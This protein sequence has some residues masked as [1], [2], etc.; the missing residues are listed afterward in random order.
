MH[1]CACLWVELESRPIGWILM[2]R[3]PRTCMIEAGEEEAVEEINQE[4]SDKVLE[5]DQKYNEIHRPVYDNRSQIIKS[6][7]D[8]WLTA[9]LSNGVLHEKK[10]NKRPFTG[11][12]FF[13]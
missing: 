9:E 4:A 2:V 11:D 12:S 10:G 5:V 1:L 7:P 3:L 8:F 13:H 6:V